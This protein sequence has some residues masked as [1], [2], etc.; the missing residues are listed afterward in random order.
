MGTVGMCA[1]LVPVLGELRE[2]TLTPCGATRALGAGWLGSLW[3]AALAFVFAGVVGPRLFAEPG[4]LAAGPMVAYAIAAGS[5]A[6]ATVGAL[7]C[8]WAHSRGR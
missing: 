7:A 4:W 3:P 6:A 5:T 2:K 1:L 8:A